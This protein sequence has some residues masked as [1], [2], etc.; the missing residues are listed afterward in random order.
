MLFA[1]LGDIEFTVLQSPAGMEL[2]GAA[3]WA[4]HALVQGKPRLQ[5]IGDELDEITL[6][7]ILHASLGNPQARLEQLRR[8]KAQHQPMALVLG[9]GDYLGAFVLTELQTMLQRTLPTGETL[10]ATARI[11]LREYTG[12]FQR[13]AP[14]P[15]LLGNGLPIQG[16]LGAPP[17]RMSLTQQVVGAAQEAGSVLN[18]GRDLYS[19][20]RS[21]GNNPAAALQ[22][23][24]ELQRV[25]TQAIGPLEVFSQGAEALGGLQG[26]VSVGRLVLGNVR[27]M[28]DSLNLA[29]LADVVGRIDRAAGQLDQSLDTLDGAALP[30]ADLTAAIATRRA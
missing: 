4:E 14:R 16:S 27:D 13:P 3:T 23:L 28:A 5:C 6:D 21:L 9:G 20:A 24:P 19:A 30:L 12:E 7:I 17:V 8:A 1:V 29:S 25:T 26:L 18:Q 10:S 22:R 2:R 15:G 11:A